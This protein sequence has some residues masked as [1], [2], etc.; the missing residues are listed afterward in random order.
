MSL[1]VL[2]TCHPLA[3]KSEHRKRGFAPDFK[4]RREQLLAHVKDVV[5]RENLKLEDLQNL[6]RQQQLPVEEGMPRSSLMQL[7][8][9]SWHLTSSNW[10]TIIKQHP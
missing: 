6:C 8:A 10:L 3:P 4:L 7:L 2:A 1:H 5:I 9:E